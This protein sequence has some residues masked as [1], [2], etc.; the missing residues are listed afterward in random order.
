MGF[1]KAHKMAQRLHRERRQP[2]HRKKVGYL[3]KKQD[4]K[5]RALDHHTKAE[6]LRK[7]KAKALERN[8]NEFH[9]HMINARVVDGVHQ[10]IRKPMEPEIR[11]K[12]AKK[13]ELLKRYNNQ[14][15]VRRKI[16]SNPKGLAN[17]DDELASE[18]TT[19]RKVPR[20]I[21][22]NKT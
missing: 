21:I 17:D 13:E 15:L 18:R 16:K 2:E 9:F 3:E 1:D 7:L 8:P 12:I 11:R 6:R 5:K 4:Y 10:D 22:F 14:V 19:K 20:H